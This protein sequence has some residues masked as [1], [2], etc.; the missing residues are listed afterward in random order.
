[1][2]IC[3]I[4]SRHS[5]LAHYVLCF[6]QMKQW[7]LKKP[8]P[9]KFQIAGKYFGLISMWKA[10]AGKNVDLRIC[11]PPQHKF[12]SGRNAEFFKNWIHVAFYSFYADKKFVGNLCVCASFCCQPCNFNFTSGK[13][14][15]IN[16]LFNRRKLS[17][18]AL[19]GIF[20]CCIY[21]VYNRR[22][23]SKEKSC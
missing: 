20:S 14:A 23:N 12:F 8:L 1:M 16:L 7:Q 13:Y 21:G 3:F 18:I 19:R 9:E 5:W 17:L 2:P 11:A 22:Y 4:F 6:L 10:S 15:E